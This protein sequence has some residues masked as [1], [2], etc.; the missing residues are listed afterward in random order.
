[1]AIL[2][3]RIVVRLL[4]ALLI[5]GCGVSPVDRLAKPPNLYSTGRNYQAERVPEAQRTVVPRLLYVTNRSQRLNGDGSVT[6]LAERSD[7]MAFGTAEVQFTRVDDWPE[8]VALTHANTSGRLPRLKVTEFR[9]GI[10][11]SKTPL[12]AERRG[13]RVVTETQAERDY[14]AYAAEFRK[15]VAAEVRRAGSGRILLFVHGFNN[16][17]DE[18]LTTLANIWHYSGR[19]SVPMAFSWPAGSSGLFK[20]FRDR[21]AGDFSVF[22]LKETLDLLASV[23]E[24]EDIDI[25]AHSRGSDVAATALRELVIRERGRGVRPKITLKTG[26]LVLAAP[27]LDVG[28]VRQRLMSE[29]VFAAF[30][31]VNVYINPDDQALAIA[32]ILT[33]EA[34][35]GRLDASDFAPGELA[36]LKKVG[37]VHFIR[38]E[39]A[40]GSG[41]SYFRDNPGA[42]SDIAL[43]LRTRA[44]PG[45]TLRPLELDHDNIWTL[46]PDYPLERLPDLDLDFVQDRR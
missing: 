9:D 33:R 32:S 15:A 6:Y 18:A 37:L 2:S 34:R 28:I 14:A 19:R 45:G 25:V 4:L 22:H 31:Q 39:G 3:G 38:V 42:M 40:G 7:S 5:A 8:L 12:P 16:D 30:E 23:P 13:G 20:Y 44:F 41:H 35:F 36:A 10:R 1:M 46:H 26:T 17:F 29:R 11:F 27:D 43:V 21:E 24:V